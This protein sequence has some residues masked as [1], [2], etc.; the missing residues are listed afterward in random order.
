MV[1]K[2][3]YWVDFNQILWIKK[4]STA[5]GMTYDAV[6]KKLLFQ[7]NNILTGLINEDLTCL[8]IVMVLLILMTVKYM[9][10]IQQ[11]LMELE[12]RWQVHKIQWNYILLIMNGFNSYKWTGTNSWNNWSWFRCCT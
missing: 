5:I 4:R 3:N 2:F 6:R 11:W 1:H 9:N 10:G 7:C 8:L 12:S